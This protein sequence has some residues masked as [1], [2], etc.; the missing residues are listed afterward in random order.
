MKTV[1]SEDTSVKNNAKVEEPKTK[2]APKWREAVIGGIPGIAI[3]AGGVLIAG[4]STPDIPEPATPADE[5]VDAPEQNDIFVPES[6]AVASKVNDDMTFGQAFAAARSEVGPGGV[7]EWH[8]HLYGTYYKTEWDAMSDEQKDDYWEAVSD[9]HV[10]HSSSVDA[11]DNAS[12]DADAGAAA[13][14]T[15]AEADSEA[16]EFQNYESEGATVEVYGVI[17]GEDGEGNMAVASVDGHGALFVDVDGDGYIDAVAVDANDDGAIDVDELE[18][19]DNTDLH[20]DDLVVDDSASA[21]E[22]QLYADN[23]D[24]TNDADTSS[25][26]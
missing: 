11:A 5:P 7:F 12:D 10:E 22:D 16:E 4:G 14:Q 15:E 18:V 25:L 3:G 2:N 6:C 9:V 19:T 8:G 24:Y 1:I 20:M 13:V 21:P 23:P 17:E 26:A